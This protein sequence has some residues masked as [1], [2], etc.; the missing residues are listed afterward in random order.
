MEK[1]E[2]DNKVANVKKYRHQHIALFV[3]GGWGVGIWNAVWWL[4][5]DFRKNKKEKAKTERTQKLG[6]WIS[7]D[8]EF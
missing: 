7:S 4:L 1:I 2:I 3:S 8:T 6:G 5:E